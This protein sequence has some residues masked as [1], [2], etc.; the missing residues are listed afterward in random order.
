LPDCDVAWPDETVLWGVR[1][2]ALH[3]SA[4]HS[5]T[6]SDP[7]TKAHCKI[8]ELREDGIDIAVALLSRFFAEEGFPARARR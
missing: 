1:R 5:L 8:V 6:S 7:K 4:L 2:N 3:F